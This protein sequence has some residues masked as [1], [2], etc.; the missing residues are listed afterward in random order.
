[1]NFDL[2]GNLGWVLALALL[3]FIFI[4]WAGRWWRARTWDREHR[5]RLSRAREGEDGSVALLEQS[6]FTII[7]SQVTHEYPLWVDDD[8]RMITLRCDHLIE[9][10]G[11]TYVA[12]VKTGEAAP[13]PTLAATRRQLLEYRV[14]Y[15]V[16]GVVLVDMNRKNIARIV[17]P[18][19][20]EK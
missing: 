17:F 8:E 19:E 10:D 6:G 18:I 2:G 1:V 3:V 4:S 5:R 12:E 13:D 15:R 11:L 7:D 14:A 20:N 16:D 9:R